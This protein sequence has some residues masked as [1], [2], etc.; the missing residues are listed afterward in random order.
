MKCVRELFL[1]KFISDKKEKVTK[2]IDILDRMKMYSVGFVKSIFT[3]L[4]KLGQKPERLLEIL[5]EYKDRLNPL[6]LMRIKEFI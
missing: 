1:I 4:K 5:D 6:T 2:L 3:Q